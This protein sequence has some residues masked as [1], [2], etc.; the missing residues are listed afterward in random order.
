MLINTTQVKQTSFLKDTGCQSTLEESR[1][2]ASP[3]LSVLSLALVP[4]TS[5][6]GLARRPRGATPR[7]GGLMVPHH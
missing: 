6:G 7:Y 1:K 2:P 5:W 4:V 3:D